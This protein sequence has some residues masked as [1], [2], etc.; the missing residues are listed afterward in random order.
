MRLRRF[1]FGLP[2]LALAAGCSEMEG[3]QVEIAPPV[4]ARIASTETTLNFESV[5]RVAAY[6]ETRTKPENLWAKAWIGP[7]GG[8]L[9]YYG[10]RIVVPAGAV[11]KVTM[12]TL[13]LPKEGTE[14]AMAEFGP[15]NVKFAQ[16]ITIEL[17]YVGTT[18]E[19]YAPKAVWYDESTK[20]WTDEG[21]TLSAD[22]LRV[23]AQVWHFSTHGTGD[24]RGGGTVSSSGG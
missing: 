11:D 20:L 12:F 22:G 14:R 3:P 23:Q 13:S 5:E 4:E 7:R 24:T 19:G 15:H 10:F 16:P 17:P 21:G 9:E 1:L 18:S 6:K 8:T 2:M